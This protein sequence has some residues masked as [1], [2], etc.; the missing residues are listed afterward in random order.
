MK[1]I[2][3]IDANGRAFI[4]QKGID[5]DWVL[6]GNTE[7]C[8]QVRN[9]DWGTSVTAEDIG[10]A[11]INHEIQNAGMFFSNEKVQEAFNSA[12]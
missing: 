3:V 5:D 10:Y 9:E 4:G 7:P 1:F 8:E 2:A 6:E 12:V 11:Y